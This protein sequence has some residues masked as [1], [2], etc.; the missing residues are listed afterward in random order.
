MVSQRK[1]NCI[2]SCS[3]FALYFPGRGFSNRRLVQFPHK[4]EGFGKE[5]QEATNNFNVSKQ[6]FTLN[7][8]PLSKNSIV[9]LCSRSL[10]QCHVMPFSRQTINPHHPSILRTIH[11]QVATPINRGYTHEPHFL[12]ATFFFPPP[13]SICTRMC[14]VA[15]THTVAVQ[16]H[17]RHCP[18]ILRTIHEQVATPIN[19]GYTHEPQFL[20]ATFFFPPPS[21]ICTRICV[22]AATH[23]VA[24]QDHRRPSYTPYCIQTKTYN[25]INKN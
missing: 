23:T 6:I 1:M 22:V 10:V 21:S 7:L 15:A 20:T 25:L 9:K 18:S 5:I 4:Y 19:C 11:A 24:D 12:T 16:D 14:V 3:R 17:R 2:C 8:S 13:S